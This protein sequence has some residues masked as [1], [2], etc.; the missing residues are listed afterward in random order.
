MP[1]NQEDTL[2]DILFVAIGTASV[3]VVRSAKEIL[4]SRYRLE[5]KF[6]RA[7]YLLVDTDTIV[8]GQDHPGYENTY[9]VRLADE[10]GRENA[11][12]FREKIVAPRI[13]SLK[14]KRLLP[15]YVTRELLDHELLSRM[16]TGEA[17]KN[18]LKGYLYLLANLRRFYKQLTLIKS[19]MV[20]PDCGIYVVYSPISGTA[21]GMWFLITALLFQEFETSSPVLINLMPSHLQGDTDHKDRNYAIF[22]WSSHLLNAMVRD[23]LSREWNIPQLTNPPIEVAVHRRQ[24]LFVLLQSAYRN[25][26]FEHLALEDFFQVTAEL[27]CLTVIG[28]HNAQGPPS[29]DSQI[30]NTETDQRMHELKAPMSPTRR[31]ASRG[32]CAV[33]YNAGLAKE[34][35]RLGVKD[36]VLRH[37]LPDSP[38]GAQASQPDDWFPIEPLPQETLNEVVGHLTDYLRRQVRTFYGEWDDRAYRKAFGESLPSSD[39][40]ATVD[41]LRRAFSQDLTDSIKNVRGDETDEFPVRRQLWE[42][43]QR[44]LDHY[45]I[46]LYRHL[47]EVLKSLQVDNAFVIQQVPEL[48]AKYQ[49]MDEAIA[50]AQRNF[51]RYRRRVSLRGAQTNPEALVRSFRLMLEQA[52]DNILLEALSGEFRDLLNDSVRYF[53]IELLHFKQRLEN[54]Y[55]ENSRE[56]EPHRNKLS[57]PISSYMDER[58]YALA[59]EKIEKYR[60]DAG[61]IIR[62]LFRRL[63]HNLDRDHLDQQ[64]LSASIDEVVLNQEGIDEFPRDIAEVVRHVASNENLLRQL[65]AKGRALTKLAGTGYEKNWCIWHSGRRTPALGEALVGLEES[66]NE[67]LSDEAFKI[68]VNDGPLPLRSGEDIELVL[69]ETILDFPLEDVETDKEMSYYWRQDELAFG[70]GNVSALSN[71]NI[72]VHRVHTDVVASAFSQQIHTESVKQNI[73]GDSERVDEGEADE[74][75]AVGSSNQQSD[76]PLKEH[77]ARAAGKLGMD[78]EDMNSE[79]EAVTDS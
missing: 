41:E 60:R 54:I 52:Y 3:G 18:P 2:R 32:Y 27:L 42:M 49:T 11:H 55:E 44:L 45:G 66:I 70:N 56:Y 58:T 65:L 13:K 79:W 14:D 51:Q 17:N 1:S 16:E 33:R 19:K 38:P 40:D 57:L 20:A 77:L 68:I 78:Q 50:A 34:A 15:P 12:N 62:E 63:D 28:K 30:T 71:G 76:D 61:L 67:I 37:L 23:G 74:G 26:G 22:G 31:F 53:E 29:V 47:G 69:A 73:P 6:C 35:T 43:I 72:S 59:R 39:I 9:R 8:Q 21:A 36:A 5:D 48:A 24:P 4:R 46:G 75:A 10:R 25:Q 64:Q 7:H